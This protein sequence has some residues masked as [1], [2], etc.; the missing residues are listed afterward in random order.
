MMGCVIT[1]LIFV[2]EI[3]MILC[4]AGYNVLNGK[5][6]IFLPLTAFMDNVTLIPVSKILMIF[7]MIYPMTSLQDADRIM[8]I[9]VENGDSEFKSWTW[10]IGK[11]MNPNSIPPDKWILRLGS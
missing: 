6:N 4:S 8:V 11:D 5:K 9:I 10:F 2:R 1:P 3:E 7:L